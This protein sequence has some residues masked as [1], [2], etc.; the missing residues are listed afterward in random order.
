[1]IRS[2]NQRMQIPARLSGIQAA[3]IPRMAACAAQEANPLYPVP[4][5]M[6]ARQLE[7]FYY[8]VSDLGQGQGLGPSPAMPA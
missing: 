4:T 6:D 2:L 5:L 3:D 1:M 7:R 8:L